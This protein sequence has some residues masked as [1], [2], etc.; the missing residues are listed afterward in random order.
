MELGELT[1]MI[2]AGEQQVDLG[3][4]SEHLRAVDLY[5]LLTEASPAPRTVLSRDHAQ[6]SRAE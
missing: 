1:R 5:F 4:L 2:L 3:E 6:C